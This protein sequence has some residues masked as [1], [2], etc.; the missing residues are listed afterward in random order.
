LQQLLEDARSGFVEPA[1]ATPS[2]DPS[3]VPDRDGAGQSSD[4]QLALDDAENP[5]QL[6]ARA[7]DLRL[8]SPKSTDINTPNSS[9]I[10][11]DR[12]ETSD[13]QRYFL[14]T[15]ARLDQGPDLD[16][17]DIGLVSLEES[18]ALIS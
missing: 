17:I 8:A 18:E 10:A 11:S 2:N 13:V 15:K 4:D 1:D 3:S 9:H 14:P 16:P 6:L 12:N 7:S 5:L